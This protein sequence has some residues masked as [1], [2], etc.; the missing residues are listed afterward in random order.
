MAGVTVIKFDGVPL[1]ESQL[2]VRKG[3]DG[4]IEIEE[5]GWDIES[6]TSF[7]KGGGSAVGKPTP[8]SL[9]LSK[10]YDTASPA[11]FNRIVKGTVFPS[12]TIHMLKSTGDS[13]LLGHYFAVVMKDVF[14]TK[15][16]MKGAEDGTVTQDVEM[17]FKEVSI[18]YKM[19]QN[20]GKLENVPNN[21][22]W[23]IVKMNENT[24]LGTATFL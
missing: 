14:I 18:G 15:V 17:V 16:S 7:L 24:T 11:I 22:T 5:W 1:G 2:D 20:D 10:N 13:G 3:S 12:V 23:N 8:Q 19:Q 4:W 9:T 6:E 21:F